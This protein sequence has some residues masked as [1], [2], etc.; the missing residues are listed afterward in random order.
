MTGIPNNAPTDA[1]DYSTVY[2]D[3]ARSMVCECGISAPDAVGTCITP[4]SDLEFTINVTSD[5]MFSGPTFDIVS[6][7]S[8]TGL[9]Y[10]VDHTITIPGGSTGNDVIVTIEDP[11]NSL[12]VLDIV[13]EDNGPCAD[14][15]GDNIFDQ[16][17]LDDDNDGI[18][19]V[20]ESPGCCLLYT[21]PSPRD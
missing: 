8:M 17:D 13:V 18:P 21:S 7:I 15:D 2:D 1:P 6:P 12:C 19:D 14:K 11:N 20:V 4:S 10:G 16:F 9:A 5:P 3:E